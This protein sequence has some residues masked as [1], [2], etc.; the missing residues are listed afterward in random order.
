[1]RDPILVLKFGSSV[2]KSEE[3]LPRAVHEIYRW[4]RQGYRVVA[5]VSAFAGVTDDLFTQARTFCANPDAALTAALVMTGEACSAALLGLALD[6]AGVPASVVDAA[7]IK[8]ET[9]GP[10]LNADPANLDVKVLLRHLVCRP[11]AVVPG[12]V[13]RQED[14]SISLL[15]RGGSDLTAL[16]L[17]QQLGA[18]CQLIKDVDG[19]YE[20][21]PS[22]KAQ[23]PRRYSQITYQDALELDGDIVQ[24]KAIRFA[25]E[26]G[27][28]F[29]VGCCN[30][31]LPTSAGAARSRFSSREVPAQP[32][33]VGL[34]GLGTVGLGVFQK[35]RSEPDCFTISGVAVLDRRKPREFPVPSDVPI[36]DAWSVVDSDC[37]LVIE[38]IGGL[39]PAAELVRIALEKGK[40]VVTANKL[41]LAVYGKQLQRVA[42]ESGAELL[43]S[44]A[45]G[46]ATP[47][48]ETVC[49]VASDYEISEIR[50]V[51]NGT[52]NFVLDS[53]A[54]GMS[55]AEA[56]RLA[57]D[58]G[59]AEADPIQDLDGSDAAQKLALLAQAAFDSQIPFQEIEKKGI[60]GI[61]EEEIR[62]LAESGQTVR[63]IARANRNQHGICYGVRPEIVAS[64][65]PFAKVKGE[66][67]CLEVQTVA[68]E[69]FTVC[70]RG[71]GRWPTSEAVFADA[72]DLWR[73]S[74]V[75]LGVSAEELLVG[76]AA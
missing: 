5:I 23:T 53:I 22:G 15:G 55:R 18:R 8:L 11:V 9:V 42:E 65:H 33:R 35:L 13:G 31:E 64:D 48:L 60:L 66:E 56:V 41:L 38:L 52:C 69:V 34:L 30:S 67:N 51:L 2:L 19:L 59:F 25:Q 10:K 57:Q 75:H 54:S 61:C 46:G 72:L 62:G 40:H 63:L 49:R 6:R 4:Y 12:F 16:F 29:E 74:A 76:G 26:Y 20:S 14:G 28:R 36:T 47:M 37:D 3:D 7:A 27:Q 43:Y 71:A 73:G 21:D 45:V 68:G 39:S 50:G 70:G 1:M 24:A 44:A 17:A 58:N 32:L